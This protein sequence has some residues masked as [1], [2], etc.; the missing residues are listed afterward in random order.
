[1]SKQLLVFN[2]E[3]RRYAIHVSIVERVVPAVEVVP[4]PSAPEIVLGVID[5]HGRVIPVIDVRKRFRLPEHEVNPSD[6]MIIANTPRRAVVLTVDRT[7]G[8]V[9]LENEA[10]TPARNIL[11]DMKY[12]EGVIR[13]EDGLILI[14]DLDAFLSLDEEAALD[15]VTSTVGIAA[16]AGRQER[17]T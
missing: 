14:H 6:Q 9:E 3:G 1:M 13:L 16:G 15:A 5:V 10:I 4:L 17:K 12:I 8:V 11:P 2:I 7:E